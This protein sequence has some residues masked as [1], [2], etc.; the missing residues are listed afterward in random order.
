MHKWS[1]SELVMYYTD[2]NWRE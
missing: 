2:R 1:K